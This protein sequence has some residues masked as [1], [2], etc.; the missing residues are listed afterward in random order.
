M[1]IKKISAN[2]ADVMLSADE[3]D[4]FGLTCHNITLKYPSMQEFI[5]CLLHIL[6]DT[7]CLSRN[8]CFTSVE[9]IPFINGGCRIHFR[10]TSEP[11]ERLYIFD[12]ADDLLDVISKLDCNSYFNTSDMS[13][14]PIENK[15]FMYI[16]CTVSLTKHDLVMLSE[17]CA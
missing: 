13:I 6:E 7:C 3:L 2:H 11:S 1:K 15:F 14:K 8:G 5:G 4:A 12:K 10:F 16:P 9:Y 17:Y